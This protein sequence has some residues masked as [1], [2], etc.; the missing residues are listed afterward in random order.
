MVIMFVGGVVLEMDL[1]TSN[2]FQLT[3]E[4]MGHPN[5]PHQYIVIT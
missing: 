3:L 5:L 1:Q 4:E 2:I